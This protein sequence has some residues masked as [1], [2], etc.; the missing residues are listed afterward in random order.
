MLVFTMASVYIQIKN[1]PTEQHHHQALFCQ[2]GFLYPTPLSL[3]LILSIS[4]SLM[5]CLLL[6]VLYGYWI[7]V[8]WCMSVSCNCIVW[9]H[10]G[11]QGISM[12]SK[13]FCWFYFGSHFYLLLWSW[14]F[15]F[16]VFFN[17]LRGEFHRLWCILLHLWANPD[18]YKMFTC[19]LQVHKSHTHVRCRSTQSPA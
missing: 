17:R 14:R 16:F 18:K 3:S 6:C 1:Q 15:Q 7:C 8:C 2:L 5:S 11:F 13:L 10:S 19:N 9:G 12:F 4:L